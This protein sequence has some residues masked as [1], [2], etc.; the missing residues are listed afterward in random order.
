MISLGGEGKKEHCD[1]SSTCVILLF[2]KPS[3]Y[4]FKGYTL[5]LPLFGFPASSAALDDCKEISAE[6]LNKQNVE[7]YGENVNLI[8]YRFLWVTY[9]LFPE[10]YLAEEVPSLAHFLQLYRKKRGSKCSKNIC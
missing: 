4:L 3:K 1:Q 8:Q 10:A 9:V 6:K 2:F 5:F 7:Q